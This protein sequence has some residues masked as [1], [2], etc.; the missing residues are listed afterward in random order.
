MQQ[1]VLHSQL[2]VAIQDN[3]LESAND[4]LQQ[5]N[6]DA[7]VRFSIGSGNQIPAI[8]LCVERGLY[9][10]SKVLIAYG[11][12]INQVDDCGYTPLHLAVSHQ[13]VDLVRLLIGHRANVNSVSNY[14][15]TPLH[16]AAQQSSLEIVQCLIDAGANLEKKDRDGRSALSVACICNQRQVAKYLIEIGC[17]VNCVDNCSN[18]PLLHAVNAGL[19]L[20][21]ELIAVLL[22]AGADPNHSNKY[23]HTALVTVVRR[24]SEHSLDGL[25]SVQDLID[26]GSHLDITSDPSSVGECPVHLSISRGQDRITEAL[27]RAG[28]DLNIRNQR[29]FSPLHRVAREGKVDLVKLLIAAGADTRLPKQFWIDEGGTVREITNAELKRV[30]QERTGTVPSLKHSSRVTFRKWLGRHADAVIKQLN[31]PNRIRQYLLLNEF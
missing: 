29:G 27:V 19:A 1:W 18:S 26:H 17:D 9:E 10:M 3:D 11:C 14:G 31:L 20:N 13:F 28:S 16:L 15:Q 25:L 2:L 4:V 8:C 30:L 12:S 21:Y 23:G 6:M 24:G 7:D 22:E 5:D